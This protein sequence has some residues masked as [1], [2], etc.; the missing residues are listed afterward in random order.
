ME[1]NIYFIVSIKLNQF[2]EARSFN[3]FLTVWQYNTVNKEA[4]KSIKG[5]W[6]YKFAQFYAKNIDLQPFKIFIFNTPPVFK[7]N[8]RTGRK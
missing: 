1:A 4:G 6:S 3:P 7:K 5:V 8:C 2:P